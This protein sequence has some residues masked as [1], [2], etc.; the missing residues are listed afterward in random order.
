M[1]LTG[2]ANHRADRKTKSLPKQELLEG[3]SVPEPQVKR[4]YQSA[5]AAVNLI[6]EA[7][8]RGESVRVTK[9]GD[10]AIREK[11]KNGFLLWISETFG[12]GAHRVAKE[13]KVVKAI[14]ATKMRIDLASAST[15]AGQQLRKFFDDIESVT[16]KG[17]VSELCTQW[18]RVKNTIQ[19]ISMQRTEVESRTKGISET[20]SSGMQG[21][22][23]SIKAKPDSA[24]KLPQFGSLEAAPQQT[25]ELAIAQD[26]TSKYTFPPDEAALFARDLHQ[27]LSELNY[28][29]R[30]L[31]DFRRLLADK[32]LMPANQSTK[33]QFSAAL[34]ALQQLSIAGKL[35]NV[36]AP[37]EEELSR[38]MKIVSRRVE[39]LPL[40]QRRFPDDLRIDCVHQGATHYAV[41]Q[42]PPEEFGTLNERLKSQSEYPKTTN[43]AVLKSLP[44]LGIL[45]EQFGKDFYRQKAEFRVN[46]KIDPT[47]S[48]ASKK[49]DNAKVNGTPSEAENAKNEWLKSFL[50]F[51]GDENAASLASYYLSQTIIGTLQQ[52]WIVQGH[53]YIETPDEG[54][55]GRNRRF[56]LSIDLLGNPPDEKCII[57]ARYINHGDTAL[58]KNSNGDI[59]QI[60]LS[61]GSARN[62]H[63][64][65]PSHVDKIRVELD[66]TEMSKQIFNPKILEGQFTRRIRLDWEKIDQ[67]ISE[68]LEAPP[69]KR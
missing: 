9:D 19:K 23:C 17:S 38:A 57:E 50:D 21:Q 36:L 64:S 52:H 32:A 22:H 48:R 49:L 20:L 25:R 42:V 60:P 56:E 28:S 10:I 27:A 16:N 3:V 59:F 14:L 30:D 7:S 62:T 5:E 11:P 1:W 12:R 46:G 39:Q 15:H 68:E 18:I 31:Q 13:E 26:L 29:F 2:R 44:K 34:A 40:L 51:F 53:S 33:T 45:E 61:I 41:W 35:M 8:R 55:Q 54:G 4:N 67:Q 37:K 63:L 58:T 65:E 66:F 69:S 43:P 24:Q 6:Y 47:M